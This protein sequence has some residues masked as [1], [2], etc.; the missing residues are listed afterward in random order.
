MMTLWVSSLQKLA[1]TAA[2]LLLHV[3][4]PR[5]GGGCLAQVPE[6]GGGGGAPRITGSDE[7]GVEWWQFRKSWELR[8][9]GCSPEEQ[10]VLALFS[11]PLLGPGLAHS[12][13][14]LF[15]VG[16]GR[17][18]RP[19]PPTVRGHTRAP[20]A[21]GRRVGTRRA[22][23]DCVGRAGAVGTHVVVLMM[24]KWCLI[25]GQLVSSCGGGSGRT[26]TPSPPLQRG[27]AGARWGRG[28]PE[29]ATVDPR[30]LPLHAIIMPAAFFTVHRHQ[31]LFLRDSTIQISDVSS[32]CMGAGSEMPSWL[33][34]GAQRAAPWRS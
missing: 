25:S 15:V 32:R 20:A 27:V 8:G 4:E 19:N 7:L 5:E 29:L 26:H 16:R 17:D 22:A 31:L 24:V 18:E 1:K 10:W 28:G 3:R 30:A 21:S 14:P 2:K 11:Y 34:L 12:R 6:H 23:L 13:A 33:W 9:E